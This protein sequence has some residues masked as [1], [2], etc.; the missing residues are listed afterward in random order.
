MQQLDLFAWAENRP[1]PSNII[2]AMPQLRRKAEAYLW[3]VL[4]KTL[5]P[6]HDD[7]VVVNIGH[8]SDTI[9]HE[10]SVA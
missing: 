4:T 1:T 2:N 5:P 8:A 7:C 3:G 10:R 6:E 9:G